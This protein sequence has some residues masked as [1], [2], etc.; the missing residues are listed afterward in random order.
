[1]R[2]FAFQLLAA[3]AQPYLRRRDCYSNSARLIRAG[4]IGSMRPP[5]YLSNRS[6]FVKLAIIRGPRLAHD[7]SKSCRATTSWRDQLSITGRQNSVRV[8]VLFLARVLQPVEF[9]PALSCRT[10]SH[11]RTTRF[12]VAK[13]L[14]FSRRDP[15][16]S[17]ASLRNLCLGYKCHRHN[18]RFVSPFFGTYVRSL[19]GDPLIKDVCFCSCPNRHHNSNHNQNSAAT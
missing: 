12:V 7:V 18:C 9:L 5:C 15:G 10:L 14:L 1:M 17:A 19:S 8:R 2:Q 11:H 4:Q 6:R 16:T 3:S 13:A